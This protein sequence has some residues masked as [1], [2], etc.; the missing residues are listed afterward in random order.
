MKETDFV[1]DNS[2]RINFENESEILEATII[3]ESEKTNKFIISQK[4]VKQLDINFDYVDKKD[5]V[6]LQVIH[7]G[8][9]SDLKISCKIMGGKPIKEFSNESFYEI[10][11]NDYFP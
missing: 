6:I 10:R 8:K 3:K 11:N 5:G 2:L 9:K 7:T 1:T 4:E